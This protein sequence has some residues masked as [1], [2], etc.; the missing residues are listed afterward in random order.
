[1]HLLRLYFCFS[2][3]EKYCTKQ[4]NKKKKKRFDFQL[5][6]LNTFQKVI[7]KVG[8]LD[9]RHDPSPILCDTVTLCVYID[10]LFCH[11]V[12]IYYIVSLTI[13]FVIALHCGSK[14]A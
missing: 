10:Q 14:Q 11:C 12:F 3:L 6:F 13:G 9:D 2:L 7:N 8:W 1:M 5:S 4:N